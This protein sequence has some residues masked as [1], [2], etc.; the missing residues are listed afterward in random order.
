VIAAVRAPQASSPGSPDAGEMM[1][2]GSAA[3]IAEAVRSA[4]IR[5]GQ[6]EVVY[7]ASDP[8]EGQAIGAQFGGAPVVAVQ[9]GALGG[10][11]AVHLAAQA[12][13][14]GDLDLV[15][16]GGTSRRAPEAALGET[17]RLSADL[18]Q[19][20]GLDIM[21]LFGETGP[22]GWQPEMA[23]Q[24]W[25][26]TGPVS[27]TETGETAA[28]VLASPAAV[29]RYNLIPRACLAARGMAA[30][31]VHRWW[32]GGMVAAGTALKRA[33][34]E[35]ADVDLLAIGEPCPG[36][37]W[38]LAGELGLDPEKSDPG[39]GRTGA[40]ALVDVIA[41]LE[42][43]AGTYALLVGFSTGGVGCATVVQRV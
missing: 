36:P 42:R 3:A 26:D 20:E 28:F 9:A 38:V 13:L 23:A 4:G 31:G 24:D 22:V 35:P 16:V 7:W 2:D 39:S 11:Q 17:R 10:Q 21:H 12:I 1:P 33:G 32:R 14:S 18:A 27:D 6:L 41:E 25:S 40:V 15:L 37:G 8:E 43:R 29:G 19:A 5:P 34:I 30:A